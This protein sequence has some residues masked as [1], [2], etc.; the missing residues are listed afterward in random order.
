MRT[1][2]FLYLYSR[3]WCKVLEVAKSP[4]QEKKKLEK[5][6]ISYKFTL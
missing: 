1:F 4:F 2:K 3:E 5:K 6:N